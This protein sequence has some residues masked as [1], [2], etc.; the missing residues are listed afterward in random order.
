MKYFLDLVSELKQGKSYPVYLFFG[1][2]NY[3]RR[4]AAKR[5]KEALLPGGADDFNFMSVNAEETS[6]PGI[7]SLAL[8]GPLFSEKRVIVVK[9]IKLFAAKKGTG[10]SAGQEKDSPPQADEISLMEYLGSP[11]P[12]T[13]LI[14]D[15]GETVDKRK[16]IFKEI[17]KAG[18]TIEFTL[19][20]AA[21]LTVWLEKQARLA[22]KT[23]EPGA[24]A[25]ILARSGHTLQSLSMEMQKLIAYSGD[26]KTIT[27]ADILA[28][29]PTNPEEDVFAVVD[30]IGERNAKRAIEG[31][32]RLLLQ[33]HPPQV[34]LSMVARQIRLILRAGEALSSGSR[35]ADLGQLLSIH[36][37]VAKKMASQQKNFN[38][39]QL[40]KA[41]NILH[42]LDIAVKSGRQEFLPGM[43]SLI[44]SLCINSHRSLDVRR[45]KK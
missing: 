13:C 41:L 43:E 33:K 40:I 36:P 31:I 25:E 6:I 22:G 38:K 10:N 3:L 21:D 19:L 39:D 45:Q 32:N 15:A 9:N 30:A 7:V 26:N 1:P 27:R 20:T 2:E 28:T 37:F 4:E 23:L 17:S 11:S 44:L 12:S 29:T 34:I 35:A 16:K 5:I 18:K 14:I 42:N 24:A 8:T